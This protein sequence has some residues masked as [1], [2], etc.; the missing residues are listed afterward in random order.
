MEGCGTS[1]CLT[2]RETMKIYTFLMLKTYLV[3]D[4]VEYVSPEHVQ[5]L[6]GDQEPGNGHPQAVGKGSQCE[7]DHEDWEE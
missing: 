5:D 6:W 1:H 4:V 2:Q 3:V 7:R